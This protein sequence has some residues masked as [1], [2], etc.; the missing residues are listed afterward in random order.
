MFVGDDL[1]NLLLLKIKNKKNCWKKFYCLNI[2]PQQTNTKMFLWYSI[3]SC[4]YGKTKKMQTYKEKI[5]E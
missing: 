3:D 1:K 4:E 5:L 2:W